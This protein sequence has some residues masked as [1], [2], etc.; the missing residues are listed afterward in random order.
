MQCDP[1]T[2]EFFAYSLCFAL[3]SHFHYPSLSQS[4]TLPA[5]HPIRMPLPFAQ[6]WCWMQMRMLTHSLHYSLLAMMLHLVAVMVYS[7]RCY[8]IAKIK[9]NKLITK[10]TFHIQFDL[11]FLEFGTPDAT[12]TNSEQKKKW[13]KSTSQLMSYLAVLIIVIVAR[14]FYRFMLHYSQCFT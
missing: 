2:C 9:I 14:K 1:L 6:Y 3:E 12:T 11:H 7:H 10:R 8:P 4:S 5:I 13:H